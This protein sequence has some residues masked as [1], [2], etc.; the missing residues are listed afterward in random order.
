[1]ANAVYVALGVKVPMGASDKESGRI[2]FDAAEILPLIEDFQTA[3][4]LHDIPGHLGAS[5][6]QVEVL[7]RAGHLVPLIPAPER[8]A[9]RQVV[10]SP[11]HLEQLLSKIMELDEL[12]DPADRWHPVGYACQRGAGPFADLFSRIMSGELRALR[13]PRQHGVASLRVHQDDVIG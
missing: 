12:T 2:V 4:S 9:V 8:G 1:M 7:Y 3:I 6:R 11:R 10:F 5:K 13:A